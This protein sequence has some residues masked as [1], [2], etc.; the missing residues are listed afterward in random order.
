[1]GVER[2]L[3]DDVVVDIVDVFRIESVGTV[4]IDNATGKERIRV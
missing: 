1:M 3:G 4:R 2:F